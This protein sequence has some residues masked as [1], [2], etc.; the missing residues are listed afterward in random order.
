MASYQE[1]HVRTQATGHCN[2]IPDI[3]PQP[4]SRFIMWFIVTFDTAGELR[5]GALGCC[6]CLKNSDQVYHRGSLMSEVWLCVIGGARC[7]FM[8]PCSTSSQTRRFR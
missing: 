7:R 5:I 6:L 1:I 4:G 8:P 3:I 2:C